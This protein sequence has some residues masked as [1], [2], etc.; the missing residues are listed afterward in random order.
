LQIPGSAAGLMYAIKYNLFTYL[1]N[2]SNCC[3]NIRCMY[4][5]RCW[6]R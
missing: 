5:V 2:L 1:L 3:V 4:A 6:W